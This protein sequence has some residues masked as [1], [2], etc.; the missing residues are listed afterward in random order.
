MDPQELRS[1]YSG[2]IAFPVTPFNQDLSLD[3]NG[4]RQNL[5]RLVQHQ[6]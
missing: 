5:E 3:L 1:K 2:V 4:L 6:T